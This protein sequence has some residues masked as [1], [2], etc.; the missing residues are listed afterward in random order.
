MSRSSWQAIVLDLGNVI[1]EWSS[2]PTSE[3]GAALKSIMKSDIYTQYE[4]GQ[5]ETEAEFCESLGRQSGIDGIHIRTTL[6]NAR[7]SL[8]SNSQLVNFIR[9]L[10]R[11]TGITVYAMSNIP[12]DAL[13]Y[14]QREHSTALDVFDH[15]FAS[16][17]AGMRKPNPDFFQMV[18]EK[19]QLVPG[20]I[21][22]VD[23]KTENVEAAQRVG[24]CGVRFE[25]TDALC[26]MLRDL[27]L[28]G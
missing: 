6:Q 7:A 27:M 14:L 11:T 25:G 13:E 3:V 28:S 17:F 5:I 15:I 22:F 1:F 20:R 23:D 4:T 24:W 19:N 9:E 12:R 21:I 18:T 2:K 16:G 8:Q 10:K 26:D